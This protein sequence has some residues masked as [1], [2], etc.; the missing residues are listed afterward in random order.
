MRGF[1]HYAAFVPMG[2]AFFVSG[3]TS[4]LVRDSV[5]QDTAQTSHC[6]GSEWVSDS[7]VAVLPV[8][9]V[10]FFV[11]HADTDE[12]RAEE[13]LS[14]CGEADRLINRKVEV[15]RSACLPAGLTR[16]ITLGVFQWCPAHVSWEADVK[17]P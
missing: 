14:K 10:A 9:I 15:N 7:S 1:V 4:T 3:C 8:P 12:L 2:L 17:S 6:S 5:Q 11:P 16:I 13:Q